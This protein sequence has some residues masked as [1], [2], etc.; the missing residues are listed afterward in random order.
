MPTSDEINQAI[1]ECLDEC[2][3][4]AHPIACLGEYLTKL[5]QRTGWTEVDVSRVQQKVLRVLTILLEPPDPVL[6]PPQEHA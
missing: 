2:Y 1:R 4:A 3:K 6:E 5:R